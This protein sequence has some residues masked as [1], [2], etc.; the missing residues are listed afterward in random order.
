MN[1]YYSH[2]DGSNPYSNGSNLHLNGDNSHS[3]GESSSHHNEDPSQGGNLGELEIIIE[4]PE[5]YGT[6]G[7]FALAAHWALPTVVRRL[8]DEVS[9]E[10]GR[11][12]LWVYLVNESNQ[13]YPRPM[14]M[15][16]FQPLGGFLDHPGAPTR[17]ESPYDYAMINSYVIPHDVFAR[18]P[19]PRDLWLLFRFIDSHDCTTMESSAVEFRTYA[20]YQQRYPNES[21]QLSREMKPGVPGPRNLGG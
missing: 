19:D 2:P 17:D 20:E 14:T 6:P 13:I 1:D 4:P 7:T 10:F 9:E 12:Q 16:F 3:N 18:W 15:V 21:H 5:F 8:R 11:S